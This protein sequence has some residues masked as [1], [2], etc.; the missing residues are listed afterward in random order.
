MEEKAVREKLKEDSPEQVRDALT[1]E[2]RH[3]WRKMTPYERFEHV[4]ALVLNAVIAVI[5]V[6]ALI[7]LIRMVLFLLVTKSLNPLE[8][9]TFQLVFGMIITLLIALEFKH[10]ITTVAFRRKSI[11]H[12]KTVVLIAVIALSRKFIIL[13]TDTS[14]GKI[15]ALAGALLALGIVYW[16]MHERE[17]SETRRT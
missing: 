5:I 9:E 7:Q 12:V 17:G 3:Q 4:V 11:T 8:Y 1:G 10:S 14:P 13:E 6:V 15:A 16:L 2:T